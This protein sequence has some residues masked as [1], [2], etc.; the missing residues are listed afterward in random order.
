MKTKKIT[1]VVAAIA[2]LLISCSSRKD[3]DFNFI[4]VKQNGLWGVVDKTGQFVIPPQYTRVTSFSGGVAA[5][6]DS[7]KKGGYINTKGEIII[8]PKYVSLTT[9][10]EGIAFVKESNNNI[11][12]IN[13]K[14]ETLFEVPENVIAIR[15]FAEGLAAFKSNNKWGFFN[16]KGEIV[17]PPTFETIYDFSNGLAAFKST[18]NLWGYINAVGEV[19]I[20][21]TFINKVTNVRN[22]STKDIS[23]KEGVAVV[24]NINIPNIGVIDKSGEWIVTPQ[25]KETNANV[26]EGLLAF[27]ENGKWGFVDMQGNKIIAPQYSSVRDFHSGLAWAQ[28]QMTK[29]FIDKTGKFVITIPIQQELSDFYGDVAFFSESDGK[30]PKPTYSYGMIDKNGKTLILANLESFSIPQYEQKF[31]IITR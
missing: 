24:Q 18:N 30:Y 22:G 15:N 20:N 27:Q 28:L 14:E 8:S 5:F 4:P 13:S 25:F 31:S 7:D 26:S 19:A 10:A 12:A 6:I 23:F 11:R 21:P 16:A 29:G 1:V 9:F 17:I 2:A 3:D